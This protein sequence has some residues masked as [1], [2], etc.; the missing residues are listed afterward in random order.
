V[1]CIVVGIHLSHCFTINIAGETYIEPGVPYNVTCTVS[2]VLENRK[3]SYSAILSNG[4]ITEISI[5]HVVTGECIY[6]TLTAS[7]LCPSSLCSCDTDGL[8]THC[9]YSTPTDLALSVT[10]RCESKNNESILTSS[11]SFIPAI[12]SKCL[13][14]MVNKSCYSEGRQLICLKNY[15]YLDLRYTQFVL[16]VSHIH[17]RYVSISNA[18]LH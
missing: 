8:A 13:V 1:N 18:Y 4:D 12:P 5:Y 6:R 17:V 7:P 15:V 3:T 11:A 10:F 2:E 14:F 16:V 9:I